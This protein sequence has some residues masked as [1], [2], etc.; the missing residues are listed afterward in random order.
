MTLIDQVRVWQLLDSWHHV[1]GL[2]ANTVRTKQM[3]PSYPLHIR[4][5]AAQCRVGRYS[6][7]G[8]A[9]IGACCL[10]GN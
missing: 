8:T 4:T 7:Y 10:P 2:H 3:V 1:A 9:L 6:P 5:D